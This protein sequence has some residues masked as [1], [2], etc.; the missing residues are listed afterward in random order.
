MDAAWASCYGDI[1][2]VYDPPIALTEVAS[3]KVPQ[4]TVSTLKTSEATRATPASA[5]SHPAVETSAVAVLP[6]NLLS[7]SVGGSAPEGSQPS[8]SHQDL[9]VVVAGLVGG[10]ERS[11]ESDLTLTSRPSQD[12]AVNAL[13]GAGNGVPKASQ[14]DQNLGGFVACTLGGAGGSN[15]SDLSSPGRDSQNGGANA[16]P[17][18]SPL[19]NGVGNNEPQDSQPSGS[20]QDVGDIVAYILGGAGR[21]QEADASSP[22]LQ[23]GDHSANEENSLPTA[24][25]DSE[26]GLYESSDLTLGSK[27]A[28]GIPTTQNLGGQGSMAS[29][30]SPDPSEADGA[31]MSMGTSSG[32]STATPT[33]ESSVISPTRTRGS[34]GDTQGGA[35]VSDANTADSSMGTM[36]SSGSKQKVCSTRFVVV[37]SGLMLLHM[38]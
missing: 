31:S 12:G 13:P 33:N 38:F 4:M 32:V 16:L 24:T 1:R 8:E 23:S 37:I 25:F 18:S 11:K 17:D 29:G 22:S 26:N 30:S 14:S 10:A 5:P 7:N 35:D 6:D 21:S 9:G 15:E 2:G 19:N 28:T 3:M 20:N 27:E 36:P 34:T